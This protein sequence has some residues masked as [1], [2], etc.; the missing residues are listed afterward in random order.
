M[1]SCEKDEDS[2]WD[3]SKSKD[4][5]DANLQHEEYIHNPEEFIDIHG[6]ERNFKSQS[7]ILSNV[8]SQRDINNQNVTQTD[9]KNTCIDSCSLPSITST[10][11]IQELK[12]PV[13]VSEECDRD[14]ACTETEKK[15]NVEN[16]DD[17][18]QSANEGGDDSDYEFI[19]VGYEENELYKE[20]L[21][22]QGDIENPESAE[23]VVNCEDESSSDDESN[24]DKE[25]EIVDEIEERKKMEEL[26]TEE[27]KLVGSFYLWYIA[28]SFF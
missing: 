11:T 4:L 10:S 16:S 2:E 22:D 18:Y 12:I 28:L 5:G 21:D 7:N 23:G 17:E 14:A 25:P 13:Q 26:L 3:E 27:E 19:P 1:A 6:N 8:N 9:Y 20:T 24:K 15:Q